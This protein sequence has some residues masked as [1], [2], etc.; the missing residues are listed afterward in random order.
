[1]TPRQQAQI[2][3]I[4]RREREELFKSASNSIT[5]VDAAI[6]GLNS[7][8]LAFQKLAK[9]LEGVDYANEKPCDICNRRGIS[10]EQAGKTIAYVA[11]VINEIERLLQF[12]KGEA[13]TRTE[14][15]GLKELLKFLKP[16]QFA[17]LN[18]WITEG[19]SSANPSLPQ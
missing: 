1:M 14:V 11:K 6:D 17:L 3:E 7:A 10:P 13:D 2:D 19:Q 15:V 8:V 16:D 9:H 12:A 5:E 4:R 18:Q